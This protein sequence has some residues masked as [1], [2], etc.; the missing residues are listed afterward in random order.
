M[1][2]AFGHQKQ[3]GKDTAVNAIYKAFSD[4]ERWSLAGPLYEVCNTVCTDFRMKFYYD[5]NPLMKMVPLV[6]GKTPR[7]LLIATGEK[8]KEIYG[9]ECW[10]D[11]A[12]EYHINSCNANLLISDVRYKE[13]AERLKEYGAVFVKVIRPNHDVEGDTADDDLLDWEGW[14]H[15]LI[16][17]DYYIEDF[18]AKAVQLYREITSAQTVRDS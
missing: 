12:I 2:I 15:L 14:D 16:N 13:E 8:L 17:D 11:L 18:E 1:I 3:Q 4:T 7:E 10:V 6:N 5:E 9:K